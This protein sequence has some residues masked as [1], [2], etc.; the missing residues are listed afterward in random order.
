MEQKQTGVLILNSSKTYGRYKKKLLYKCITY[1]TNEII[2]IPY[3]IKL[4]FSKHIKNKFV[5]FQQIINESSLPNSPSPSLPPSL[6]IGQ[7]THVFG[8]VDN[9]EAFYE[10]QYH[11]R[12]IS[13]MPT[14]ITSKNSK[15]N[16]TKDEIFTIMNE[17]ISSKNIEDRTHYHVFTI[18]NERTQHY[19]DAFSITKIDNIENACELWKLSIYITNVAFYVQE[20][21]LW[22]ALR[23][24]IISNIYL[25]HRK[26][27]ILPS[28]LVD[29]LSLNEVTMAS[30]SNNRL[31]LCLDVIIDDT[32]KIMNHEMKEVLIS[33]NK[34]Y[35][36]KGAEL[37]NDADYIKMFEISSNGY[38]HITDSRSFVSHWM[39]YYNENIFHSTNLC[40]TKKYN[41]IYSHH[42]KNENHNHDENHKNIINRLNQS[43][44]KGYYLY[45]NNNDESNQA[46]IHATSPLRRIVD[47]YNQSLL[48]SL[49]RLKIIELEYLNRINK[50]INKLQME[51]RIIRQC[52]NNAEIIEKHYTGIVIHSERPQI[53]DTTNENNYFKYSIYIDELN[54]IS[55]IKTEK[56][57]PLNSTC[58]IQ[59]YLFHDEYQ[60]N[61]KIKIR[62][63]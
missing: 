15:Y 63:L 41:Y 39:E 49:D 43:H 59:L 35:T 16:Y 31:A 56:E 21:N 7:L 9:L 10:Y 19:D 4:E 53:K 47:I 8:D 55:Q 61:K 38:K 32:G 54:Y 52:F 1:K 30:K 20:L 37:L 40:H 51:T 5:V 62:V 12:I 29:N 22:E 45:D 25:P 50:Q 48:L 26:I 33:V 2:F 18:D 42:Y 24:N 58:Q 17:R 27:G 44:P 46:Y 60:I 36:Y 11:S 13:L 14:K 3:E 6:P 34:N 57:Y 23:E 28:S